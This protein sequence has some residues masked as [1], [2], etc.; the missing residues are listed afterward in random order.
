MIRL[1]VLGI[2]YLPNSFAFIAYPSNIQ[3]YLCSYFKNTKLKTKCILIRKKK[4]LI[5]FYCTQNQLNRFEEISNVCNLLR[6]KF[7]N[8]CLKQIAE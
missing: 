3:L 2:T 1:L 5:V 8:A 4:F 7:R 6:L